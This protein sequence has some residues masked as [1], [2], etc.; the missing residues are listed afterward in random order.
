MHSYY[1]PA[2]E[3]S[4]QE[5]DLWYT[6]SRTRSTHRDSEVRNSLFVKDK[7]G[8]RTIPTSMSQSPSRTVDYQ[9]SRMVFGGLRP[10]PLRLVV[11]SGV[12]SERA[13]DNTMADPQFST[14]GYDDLRS[15]PVRLSRRTAIRASTRSTR[16]T[17]TTAERRD[18]K[19]STHFL[20]TT[21]YHTSIAQPTP[22]PI[23]LRRF[24]FKEDPE[25]FTSILAGRETTTV[26]LTT[27]PPEQVAPL[28]PSSP[29]SRKCLSPLVSTKHRPRQA[30][31][32]TPSQPPQNLAEELRAIGEQAPEG[33]VAEMTQCR[34]Q[35]TFEEILGERKIST[36][37][38]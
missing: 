35:T 30:S 10:R 5:A 6:M 1:L 3:V 7:Y 9:P 16:N 24:S 29:E 34:I 28:L 8:W 38:L 19:M 21:S 27:L 15:N 20:V 17:N 13:T 2:D 32:S 26:L 25:T 33:E 11:R 22:Q 12:G 31:A 4:L 14:H 23:R 36:A 37:L 18:S